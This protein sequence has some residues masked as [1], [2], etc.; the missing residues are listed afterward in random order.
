MLIPIFISG[1]IDNKI[2]KT[3]KI[4]SFNE[5]FNVKYKG[6]NEIYS[7]YAVYADEANQFFKFL[8]FED[9]KFHWVYGELYEPT[10]E[11]K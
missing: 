5:M 7:V 3:N 4:R 2:S 1:C 9:K 8:I 11:I 6:N 10:G